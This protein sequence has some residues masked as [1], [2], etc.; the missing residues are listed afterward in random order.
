VP[1]ESVEARRARLAPGARWLRAERERRD[2]SGSELARRTGI[3]QERISAYERAQD[4]PPADVVR[5]LAKVFEMTEL[6][7]WRNLRK[8]FPAVTDEDVIAE[9]RRRWPSAIEDVLGGSVPEPRRPEPRRHEVR[10]YPRPVTETDE[11][12]CCASQAQ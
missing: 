3:R 7:V 10:R 8:P 5:S 4:E 11:P 6:E 9:V 2:W 12:G 1:R